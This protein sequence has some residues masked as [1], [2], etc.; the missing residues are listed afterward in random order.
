MENCSN[1]GKPEVCTCILDEEEE[2]PRASVIDI[3]M[4]LVG[5]LLL[6]LFLAWLVGFISG[7]TQLRF[8]EFFFLSLSRLWD[9]IKHI[10]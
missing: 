10:L 2:A 3:I 1:C 9:A 8:S 7:F 5:F 4:G 6:M